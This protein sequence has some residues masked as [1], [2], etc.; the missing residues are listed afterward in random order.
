[1]KGESILKV[2]IQKIGY[3]NCVLIGFLLIFWISVFLIGGIVGAY[4]WTL[5]KLVL[6]FIGALGLLMNLMFFIILFFRKS[7]SLKLAFNVMVNILMIFPILMTMNIIPFAYPNTV[8]RAQ[9]SVTVDFPL[10]EQTVVGWGGNNVKDNLP[11][12]TWSSEKWAYDLLMEPFNINSDNNEDYGIWNKKIHSPVSGEVIAAYDGEDDITPGSEDFN[13]LEGNYVYIKIKETGTYLLLNHLKKDSALV[14]VGDKV[15]PGDLLGRVGN[16]GSTSE[17]HLHIHHQRQNPTKTIYPV[18][19]EG[20]PLFF[21]DLNVS[22]MPRKDDIV[23]P[24]N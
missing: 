19:A 11:H 22:S 15:K 7:K 21:R 2:V 17:P 20:L 9:P 3:I 4:L 8:E 23:T 10:K 13:S 1:M 18:V 14:K 16:S 12:A 6:P 5:L 24:K